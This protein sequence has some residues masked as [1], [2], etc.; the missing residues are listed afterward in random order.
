MMYKP[1]WIRLFF[2]RR[3]WLQ[4]K[5]PEMSIWF[6]SRFIRNIMPP[7][8]IK[9]PTCDGNGFIVVDRKIIGHYYDKQGNITGTSYHV[10]SKACPTCFP[11]HPGWIMIDEG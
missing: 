9:C 7:L 10:Y 2:R 4:D 3:W 6:T 1:K 11:C 8:M 5:T